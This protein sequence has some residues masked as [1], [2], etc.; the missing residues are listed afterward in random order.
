MGG[1]AELLGGLL[2][3]AG[4]ACWVFDVRD[5]GTRFYSFSAYLN[6]APWKAP[7][8]MELDEVHAQRGLTGPNA[9][10]IAFGAFVMLIGVVLCVAGISSL[11]G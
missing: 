7:V 8:R 9:S 11:L 1:V 4:G 10:R 2:T 5:V 6:T 3:V